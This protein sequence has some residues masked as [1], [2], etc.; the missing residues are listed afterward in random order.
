V[1]DMKEV[2]H[3]CCIAYY[4]NVCFCCLVAKLKKF[5]GIHTDVPSFFVLFPFLASQEATSIPR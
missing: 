3:A 5:S 2:E 1:P 4:H